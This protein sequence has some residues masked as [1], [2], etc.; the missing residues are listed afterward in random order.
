MIVCLCR[1]LSDHA[2]HARLHAGGVS[3]ARSLI[4]ACGA[5]GD[6]GSCAWMLEAL[7]DGERGQ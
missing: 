3:A 6:C 5:G 7:L 4:D 2:I 1:G